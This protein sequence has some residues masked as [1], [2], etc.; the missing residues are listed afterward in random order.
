LTSENVTLIYYLFAY[1]HSSHPL[2]LYRSCIELHET[3]TP[4]YGH[5][6]TD[7]IGKWKTKIPHPSPSGPWGEVD[8]SS[9]HASYI[10]VA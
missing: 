5:D 4:H 6:E 7:H 3:P 2:S 9:K 1:H 10:W 8:G